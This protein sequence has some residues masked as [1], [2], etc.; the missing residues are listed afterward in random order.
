MNIPDETKCKRDTGLL[1]DAVVYNLRFGG[2]TKIVDFAKSYY[3]GNRVKHI[4]NELTE[5][6]AAYKFAVS[7]MVLAM[8]GTLP[9]GVY[10][11]EAPFYDVNILDDPNEFFPKCVKIESTLN[12]YAGIVE[13]LLTEG[14]GLIQPEP[15]NNQ[16]SG[17]WT[18]RRTYS[19]YNL[20][21]DPLLLE[22]ECNNVVESI[23][24]LNGVL[25]GI[26]NNGPSSVEKTN[27]DFIDGEN[28][29][30]E[31]YYEN[32]DI[33]KTNPT[34]SLLV[35]INGVTQLFGSYDIIRSEDPSVTDIISFSDTQNGNK[36][37]I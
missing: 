1:V 13:T 2:T 31:L 18:T 22:Y 17:N 30:F 7:L 28:T 35:F 26:L 36:K 19:N 37:K 12:S 33:V 23:K 11:S 14:I 16:R 3:I 32:G 15:E 8:R 29:D 5:S 9:T 21:A 6:V 24:T 27:P 25:D 34:E 20:I 4:N 10:T